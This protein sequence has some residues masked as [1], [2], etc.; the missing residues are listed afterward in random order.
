M[1]NELYARGIYDPLGT[2]SVPDPTGQLDGTSLPTPGDNG[3]ALFDSQ[4]GFISNAVAQRVFFTSSTPAPAAFSNTDGSGFS[5]PNFNAS[6]SAFPTD[7]WRLNAMGY[8]QCL[9]FDI[10]PAYS[11]FDFQDRSGKSDVLGDINAAAPIVFYWHGG[12][13]DVGYATNRDGIL[14]VVS[15]FCRQGFHVVVP[16]YRRG[17]SPIA[18]NSNNLFEQIGVQSW[19]NTDLATGA[20]GDQAPTGGPVPANGYNNGNGFAS[21]SNDFFMDT[22]NGIEGLAIQD[23]MDASEYVIDNI[24]NILPNAVTRFIMWGNSAGGSVCCHLGLTPGTSAQV[25]A[26]PALMTQWYKINRKIMACAPNFGTCNVD[27]IYGADIAGWTHKPAVLYNFQGIDQLSPI[28]D[29]HIFWQDQMMIARG[30]FD[31]WQDLNTK[32]YNVVGF[33]DIAGGHGYGNLQIGKS[34]A[35]AAPDEVDMIRVEH[36]DYMVRYLSLCRAGTQP[37]NHFVFKLFEEANSGNT[38]SS[39]DSALDYPFARYFITLSAGNAALMYNPNGGKSAVDPN[40]YSVI[41]QA[42]T[43]SSLSFYGP[44]G[45]ADEGWSSYWFGDAITPT[46]SNFFDVDPSTGDIGTYSEE[47]RAE[48]IIDDAFPDVDIDLFNSLYYSNY[49]TR[50]SPAP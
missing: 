22:S 9:F 27:S 1:A 5:F 36:I 18:R 38:Y 3:S 47:G 48:V 43:A 24:N 40:L 13:F 33:C 14:D 50:D 4:P 25:S 32:G 34:S 10:F 31:L 8:P 49:D 45:G 16:E 15:H 6:V 41:T 35:Q 42:L 2:N 30:T 12:G 26:N 44:N 7:C 21:K 28:R 19:L 29:S 37:P 23:A 39:L 17:W 46:P 11:E 20:S